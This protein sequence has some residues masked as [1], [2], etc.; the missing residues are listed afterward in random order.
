[1]IRTK[2]RFAFFMTKTKSRFLFM[3]D[4]TFQYDFSFIQVRNTS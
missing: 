1:M 2:G 4:L 3:Y